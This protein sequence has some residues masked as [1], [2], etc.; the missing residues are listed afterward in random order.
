MKTLLGDYFFMVPS[1]LFIKKAAWKA[2]DGEGASPGLSAMVGKRVA[3]EVELSEGDKFDSGLLKRITGGESLTCRPLYGGF[4]NFQPQAVPVFL[5]NHTPGTNDF[6]GGL[7][8]RLRII[9][10]DH[11]VRGTD[12]EDKEL[13]AK[14][15]AEASGIFNWCLRGLREYKKLGGL[16]EPDEIKANVKRYFENENVVSRFLADQAE[17]RANGITVSEG[18]KSK[19]KLAS[20]SEM[21]ATFKDWAKTS[22]EECDSQR[23]FINRM[24]QLGHR[25]VK[26]RNNRKY[27]Q[28]QLK[29]PKGPM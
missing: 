26:D 19:L 18:D 6:S 11:I 12:K 29:F 5:S 23:W 7:Q 4:F 3:C 24:K 10:F 28:F 9:G 20:F 25:T 17:I 2:S 22:N 16:K 1:G 8:S 27:Y 21:Y 15:A 14:L 13:S